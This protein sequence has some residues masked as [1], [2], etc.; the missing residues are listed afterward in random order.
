MQNYDLF[1]LTES[2]RIDEKQITLNSSD[3]H[4][5]VTVFRKKSGDRIEISDGQ[6][7]RYT[8]RIVMADKKQIVLEIESIE[9]I[10]K[11]LPQIKL[12][13]AL[14]KGSNFD[15]QLEKS[16]ELGA[17]EFQPLIT[18]NIQANK[19][20]VGK[21]R[22]V[23]LKASKQAKQYQLPVIYEPTKL[24]QMKRKE[25]ELWIVPELGVD[26]RDLS[27]SDF[28]SIHTICIFIG[29]EGGFSKAEVDFFHSN[30]A[31]FISLGDLRLRAETAAWS[32][33]IQVQHVLKQVRIQ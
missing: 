20:K 8:C 11:K 13:N 6:F 5:I 17:T 4:H 9:L 22:D 27:F 26:T 32:A 14:L 25:K 2:D 16:V 7:K 1:F 33:L 23:I 12:C 21:W 28:E 30:H 19:S 18:D 24:R 3:V 15:L 10:Q 29:P 31:V